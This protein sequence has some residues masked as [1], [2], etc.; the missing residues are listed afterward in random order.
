M[1]DAR[2]LKFDKKSLYSVV[3]KRRTKLEGQIDPSEQTLTESHR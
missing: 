1:Y 3:I 2:G